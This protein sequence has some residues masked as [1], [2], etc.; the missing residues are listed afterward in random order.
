VGDNRDRVLVIDSDRHEA[1]LLVETALEPFGY[2]AEW[3]DNGGIGLSLIMENPPD[4]LLLDLDLEGLSG[5]DIL[6]ALNAQ[7]IDIPVIVLT[8]RGY[9]GEALHA[10]RLGAKDYLV[11]PLREAEVIQAVERSLKEIRLRRERETLLAEVQYAAQEAQQ[12]L[13]ELKTLMGIGKSV[14]ALGRPEQ[15]FDRV[16]RAAVYLTRAESA[17]LFLRDSSSEGLVLHAGQ[18]LSRNLLDRMGQQV[19]D[20]LASLVMRSQETYIATSEDFQQFQPAQEDARAIIYAPLVIHERPIGLLWVANTRLAFEYHMR[21]LMTALA[22]YAAIAVVNVRFFSAMQERSRQL[23]VAYNQLRAH[24]GDAASTERAK[25]QGAVEMALYMRRPLTEL[26]GNMNLFRTGEMGPLH[27]Q[28][29]AAVDV[30]H[31]QLADLVD[32]I[33]SLVPHDDEL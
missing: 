26:L 27:M 10:F 22:D 8:D 6:A 7:A 29:Q 5:Q 21:D 11:R 13:T 33:D 18:N 23:E 4:V 16:V 19:E 17:G 28:H 2:D 12:R 20:G 15:V 1:S 9:E 30:M 32:L 31:R 3:I 24:Q 14:T 25:R